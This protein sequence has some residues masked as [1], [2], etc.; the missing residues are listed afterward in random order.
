M[1]SWQLGK[2]N[3]AL[4]KTEKSFEPL[5]KGKSRIRIAGCGLCHTD[6]GFIYTDVKTRRELP[7]VLGHEISG[8]VVEG[9]KLNK[10]VIIPAVMPCG[11][12]PAC[13]TGNDRICSSQIM[14]G[15]DIDGGF[16]EYIDVPSRFLIEIQEKQNPEALARLSIIADAVT[17]PLQAV[18]NLE[19]KKQELAVVIGCGGV[20]S[21]A[22]LIAKAYGAHVI[23]FDIDD[24]KLEKLNMAGIDHSLNIKNSE[25][26]E[27]KSWIKNIV[28][29]N[30]YPRFGHKIFETSGTKAGQELAFT[31]MGFGTRIAIVGFTMEKV[32]IRLSNL[33]AYDARLIGNWGASPSVYPEAIQMALGGN[34][35]LNDFTELYPLDK[36]N[37]VI[38]MAH[39]GEL[40][41]RAVLVPG[42]V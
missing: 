7:L 4:V 30:G 17:T 15:N 35:K 9:N 36:I 12:C 26:Y 25:P 40:V 38:N 16:S 31:L 19:L 22:A 27:V 33:M 34:L 20:G 1:I 32:N 24:R 10:Q 6:L 39:K 21:Y 23:G 18:H 5:E 2:K 8:T 3:Q 14:P 13:R 29:E 11:E 41:K 42:M 37:E 28:K